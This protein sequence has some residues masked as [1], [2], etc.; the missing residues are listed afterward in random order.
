MTDHFAEFAI[1]DTDLTRKAYDLAF[2]LETPAIAH[3]SVRSYLFA[4]A[5][6]HGQGLT[7]GSGYDDE[8]L[9]LAC[10]LH[11]AGLSERGN[12]DQRF[13]VDGAD[14]AA[15]FLRENRFAEDRVQTV[16]E[17]IA[18]HSSTGIAHRM[19]AEIALAHGGIGM[20]VVARGA[21]GLPDGVAG[22]AHA[23]FPRLQE[24]C[25]LAEAIIAQGVRNPAKAPMGSLA[26][27]LV[28]QAD[29]GAA[30]PHW[31]DLVGQAWRGVA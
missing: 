3:H 20:D 15:G 24:G 9:F 10:V 18:L 13:E 4:R 27:E 30:R 12:G 29:P 14:L 11:D 2:S 8:V 31:K 22:R 28:R 26:Y 5:I 6:G 21:E 17:A 7:P 16:W 1:P 23:A 19:R 25:G